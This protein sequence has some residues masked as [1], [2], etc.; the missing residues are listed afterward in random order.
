VV[1][2]GVWREDTETTPMIWWIRTQG[3]CLWGAGIDGDIPADGGFP[4]RPH[5]IQS[6]DGRIGSNFVITGEII[7]LG[8]GEVGAP[9]LPSSA[10]LR[11]HI[12]FGEAGQI[13]LREDRE[14][15]VTGL[16]CPDPS[17]Y[18][19]DPLVLIPDE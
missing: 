1:L 11:M 5:E 13:T 18:C 4:V 10:P 12:E 17:G 8:P 16:H 19:P 15:G 9:P 2:N 6:L 3:N 14:P 7:W